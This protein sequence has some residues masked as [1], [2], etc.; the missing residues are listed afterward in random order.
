MRDRGAQLIAVDSQRLGCVE[1]THLKQT[2]RA[3]MARVMHSLKW[4]QRCHWVMCRLGSGSARYEGSNGFEAAWEQNP[5][6]SAENGSQT[7][8]TSQIF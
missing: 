7:R 1:R 4:P 5:R 3:E 6:N 8:S 2:S